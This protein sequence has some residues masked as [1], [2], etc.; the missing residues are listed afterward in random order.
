MCVERE[1]QEEE[2]DLGM[3]EDRE[4]KKI[5]GVS[6]VPSGLLSGFLDEKEVRILELAE[7]GFRFRTARKIESPEFVQVC[8]YDMDQKKYRKVRLRRRERHHAQAAENCSQSTVNRAQ[9]AEACGRNTPCHAQEAEECGRDTTHHAQAAE[10]HAQ[11]GNVPAE[12]VGVFS[13]E[14]ESEEP[15]QAVYCVMVDSD[16]YRREVQ[17]LLSR[18]GRYIRCRLELDD[19]EL[20]QEM[21]GY[22]A[23]EDEEH[24]ETLREQKKEWFL[25]RDG[26]TKKQIGYTKIHAQE[27][28]KEDTDLRSAE[29]SLAQ[30]MEIALELDRPALYEAYLSFP[31][32][33]FVRQY[34]EQNFLS[35]HL[36]AKRQVNRLYIG[37]SFCHLLFPNENLLFS[38]LEKAKAEQLAVTVTFPYVRDYQL[39]QME[40]LLQKLEA[41]CVANER[42]IEAV[43]NDWGMLEIIKSRKMQ[44]SNYMKFCFG[45]LLNKR[46]KDPRMQYYL[47]K[48]E[49]GEMYAQNS[50]NAEFYQRRLEEEYRIARWE[51]ETCGYRQKLPSGCHSIHWPF[52]QTNTSHYCPLYAVQ[53]N[54]AR[55]RQELPKQCAEY[56][57]ES[58]FL[59]PKHLLMVGRYNS[60]FGLDLESVKKTDEMMEFYAAQGADRLVVNLL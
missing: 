16:A 20:A 17:G 23:A 59:Y 45:L 40:H 18:Y 10:G 27:K 47:G 39:E 36:L 52:Y 1:E 53:K 11:N 44:N 57:R 42:E 2:G 24:F 50:L 51:W 58:A 21:T 43:V 4:E 15:F 34:W 32:D 49:R 14:L 29:N 26:K 6:M 8:F 41:W 54:G 3:Q 48:Q 13:M 25:G 30:E 19:G 35:F 12:Y 37:N 31:K 5:A 60:L 38:L 22:P 55:G 56:C 9:K 7:E 28:T 46:K 33:V